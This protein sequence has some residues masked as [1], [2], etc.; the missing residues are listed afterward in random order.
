VPARGPDDDDVSTAVSICMSGGGAGAA[1]MLGGLRWP[2]EQWLGGC[3]WLCSCRQPA[4]LAVHLVHDFAA[5]LAVICLW[6]A[7]WK[8][9]AATVPGWLYLGGC[10]CGCACPFSFC[11]G[12]HWGAALRC[13]AWSPWSQCSRAASCL[14]ALLPCADV[15]GCAAP[16]HQRQSALCQR[17]LSWSDL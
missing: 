6:V 2:P 7:G 12:R 8:A 13:P 10:G 17:V 1:F 11:P 5:E 15:S 3:V 14:T 4:V 16:S 9:A